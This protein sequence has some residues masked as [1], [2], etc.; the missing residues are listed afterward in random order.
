MTTPNDMRNE[1]A[2]RIFS[3]CHDADDGAE[4]MALF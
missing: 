3:A 1:E 2:W 4:T